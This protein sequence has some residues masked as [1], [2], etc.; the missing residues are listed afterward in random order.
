M[1]LGGF[2]RGRARLA[3]F[4]G[5]NIHGVQRYHLFIPGLDPATIKQWGFA[6]TQQE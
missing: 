6:E 1:K 3:D 5:N 2:H 4:K